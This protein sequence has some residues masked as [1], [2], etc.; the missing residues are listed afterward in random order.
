MACA[1]GRRRLVCVVVEKC[2]FRIGEGVAEWRVVLVRL[3][4]VQLLLVA[5]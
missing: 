5:W 2:A 1:P 3:V 4:G